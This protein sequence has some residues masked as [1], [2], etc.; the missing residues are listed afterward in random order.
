MKQSEI[1]KKV[2]QLKKEVSEKLPEFYKMISEY[3]DMKDSNRPEFIHLHQDAFGADYQE[4]EYALLGKIIKLCGVYGISV[5]IVGTNRTKITGTKQD[6]IK[7]QQN[8]L[9]QKDKTK[10][11]SES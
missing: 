1:D 11:H 3:C 9:G 2:E 5:K 8:I 10:I 4:R 7:Q 6:G